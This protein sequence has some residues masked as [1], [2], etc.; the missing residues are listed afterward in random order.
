M[1][2]LSAVL[3]VARSTVLRTMLSFVLEE[4]GYGAVAAV[5]AGEGLQK[6]RARP[7]SLVL[8]DAGAKDGREFLQRKLIDEDGRARPR[9]PVL[10]VATN[11]ENTS[12]SRFDDVMG[13]VHTPRE[14][15]EAVASVLTPRRESQSK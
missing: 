13:I 9:V 5:D 6:F 12:L 10:V 7:P 15:R 8:L 14:L 4:E 2:V 11:G 3:I 1:T